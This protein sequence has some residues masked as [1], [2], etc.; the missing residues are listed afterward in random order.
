MNLAPAAWASKA[1]RVLDRC[2]LSCPLMEQLWQSILASKC[3]M[4][5]AA[6]ARV[7][8]KVLGTPL[9]RFATGIDGWL[10]GDCNR[11]HT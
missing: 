2:G 8:W 5:A 3:I 1:G 11:P 9:E 7:P 6:R 4:S 10:A